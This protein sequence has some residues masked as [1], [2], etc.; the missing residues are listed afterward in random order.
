MT[1]PITYPYVLEKSKGKRGYIQ[2]SSRI[3][4][5]IVVNIVVARFLDTVLTLPKG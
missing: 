4:L 3:A 2:V 1:V 5:I